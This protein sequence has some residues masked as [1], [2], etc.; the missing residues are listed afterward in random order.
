MVAVEVQE[1]LAKATNVADL[2]NRIRVVEQ[3]RH[4]RA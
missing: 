1:Y 3:Q 2:E 4:F